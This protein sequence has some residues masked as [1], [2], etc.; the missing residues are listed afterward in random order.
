MF[1]TRRNFEKNSLTNNHIEF[2][3]SSSNLRARNYNIEESNINKTLMIS[4]NIIASVPTST[5]AIV[6]YACLQ[7]INLMYSRNIENVIKNAFFNLGLNELDLIPQESIIE[8][9]E[10][11]S[12]NKKKYPNIEIIGSKTCKEFLDYI[13]QNYNLEIFH[14]EINNKILYDKR[15]T[16]NPHIIK[17]EL[18]RSRTKI[19]ELY[20]NQ[21]KN[22]KENIKEKNKKYFMIKIY[23]RIKNDELNNIEEI[24]DFPLIKYIPYFESE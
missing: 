1:N 5:S 2:I 17:R 10:E 7:I 21:I 8:E 9:K 12:S 15:I 24:Y 13:Q 20:F 14:F 16:K 11:E 6:G 22:S 4:G 18:E 23:C 19:E 3:Q